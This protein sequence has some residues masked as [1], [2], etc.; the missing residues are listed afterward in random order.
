MIQG[1]TLVI[2]VTDQGKGFDKSKVEIPNI[3]KKLARSVH[4]PFTEPSGN[5]RNVPVRFWNVHVRL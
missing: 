1:D 4:G 2:K 5:L 3:E